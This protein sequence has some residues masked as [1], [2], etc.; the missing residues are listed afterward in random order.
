[1]RWR[2]WWHVKSRARSPTCMPPPGGSAPLLKWHSSKVFLGHI[3]VGCKPGRGQAETAIQGALPA[4][5][6]RSV[7]TCRKPM[8]NADRPFG[9][10]LSSSHTVL[11]AHDNLLHPL[12]P[13]FH[14]TRA[15]LLL[16]CSERPA[17][18]CQ[19]PLSRWK[20]WPTSSSGRLSGRAPPAARSRPLA[21]AACPSVRQR[22]PF[23]R[24][25]C[26]HPQSCIARGVAGRRRREAGCSCADT[27][28]RGEPDLTA[29]ALPFRRP[30]LWLH[31]A[32]RI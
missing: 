7:L 1:M 20:C 21:A 24:S 28:A 10:D 23:L 27:A 15:R 5:H 30:P 9:S 12:L 22:Y 6:S 17:W 11:Q 26:C 2:W 31:P 16:G 18:W 13:A 19:P 25:V 29:T 14:Q 3:A 8:S 4:V 32:E